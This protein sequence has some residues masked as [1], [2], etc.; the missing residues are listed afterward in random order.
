MLLLVE[1][2]AI[3]INLVAVFHLRYMVFLPSNVVSNTV[4]HTKIRMMPSVQNMEVL[5]LL[6][7]H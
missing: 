2:F 4:M 1:Q 6:K 5:K 3:L 7:L